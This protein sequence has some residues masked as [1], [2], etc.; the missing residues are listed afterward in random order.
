M[1]S[2]ETIHSFTQSG[3]L[4][5]PTFGKVNYFVRTGPEIQWRK[6][7]IARKTGMLITRDAKKFQRFNGLTPFDLFICVGEEPGN[8]ILRS[9]ENPRHDNF[10]VERIE[11]EDKRKAAE[12]AYEAFSQEIRELLAELAPLKVEQTSL[13]DDLDDLFQLPDFEESVDGEG[14]EASTK[15]KISG[16]RTTKPSR[17]LR[18]TKHG[19]GTGKGVKRTPAGKHKPPPW[20]GKELFDSNGSAVIVTSWKD[21]TQTEHLRIV[22]QGSNSSKA[23]VY[24]TVAAPGDY[25]LDLFRAGEQDIQFLA[26][27]DERSKRIKTTKENERVTLELQ[28]EPRDLDYAIDGVTHVV[29]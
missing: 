1:H 25:I 14:N 8:S 20:L 2:V 12:K 23:L 5:S 16:V 10:E 29:S 26:I 19:T 4:N 21:V 6:V 7:G 11:N 27:K 17:T 22:P 9:M 18:P 24:L 28:I 3:T 15:P 13:I